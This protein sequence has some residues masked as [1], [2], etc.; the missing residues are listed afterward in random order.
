VADRSQT[1]RTQVIEARNLTKKYGTTTAVDDISFT[2]QRGLVTGFLGPNG[3]GKTT[4]IRMI[5]GLDRPTSGSVT[6]N[7]QPYGRIKRPLHHVGAVLET[8][9]VHGGRNAY[10]HLLCLAQSNGIGERRIPEVLDLVGLAR[11]AKRR[12]KGFSLGMSQRLALAAALLG[13]PEVLVCDEPVNGLDPEGIL[14]ARSLL[15]RLAAEGRAVLVSSHLMSEMAL[16][17]D[18]LLVIGK[19]KLIADDTLEAVIS[20]GTRRAVSV[21]SPRLDDLA[22]LLRAAGAMVR[23][24]APQTARV[25]G[26]SSGQVGDLAAAAAIAIH[27]LTDITASLEDAFMTLT[28]EAAEFAAADGRPMT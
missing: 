16:T 22:P 14:W 3:A 17:A 21:T 8:G 27:Q 5:M 12:P 24:A 6:V 13:D 26:I 28:S 9:A 4:T 25:E 2:V 7:G 18:R 15:G 11:V 20:R 23:S 19:G 10:N 1:E